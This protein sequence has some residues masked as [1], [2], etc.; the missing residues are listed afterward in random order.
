MSYPTKVYAYS[1]CSTC[2]NALK[3]LKDHDVPHE[4]LAIRETPPTKAELKR[5]LA[6]YGGQVRKLF[7]T[8]GQDYRALGLGERLD[9]MSEDEALA[10]LSENG[11]LVK[12]PFVL[13]KQGGVVGFKADQWKELFG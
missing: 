5:L 3:F 10:L 9:G 13:T 8:S 7:N 11:N 4:V 2:R 6:V 1:G 12:R